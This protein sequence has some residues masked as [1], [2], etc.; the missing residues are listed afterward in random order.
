VQQGEVRIDGKPIGDYTQK[1][2]REQIA[3]VSQKP[4]LFCDTI[5]ANISYGRHFSREKIEN[6]AKRAYA[7][8]FICRLPEQYDFMLAETGQN[9]SG[10][11]QQRLAIARALAKE[12]PILILDEATSSLDALSEVRIKNAIA[13]LH[14]E[15]TQI[16]I[17]HRLSTIEHADRILY[18]ERGIKIAEGSKQELLETCEPFRR[19][20]EALYHTEKVEAGIE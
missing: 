17:A 11:Q 4:F 18:L 8:E 5:A 2:L 13:D 12:A 7:D 19:M 20:W 14:G 9:L 16:L 3:F 6:A 15:V 10:G 1:S